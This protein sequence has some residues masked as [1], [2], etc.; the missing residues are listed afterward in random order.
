M[1]LTPR[2]YRTAV[3][4]LS[5]G[6]FATFKP[7]PAGSIGRLLDSRLFSPFKPQADELND[8]PPTSERQTADEQTTTNNKEIRDKEI[9]SEA[10]TIA[11]P[12]FETVKLQAAKIGLP[13]IEA[14]KFFNYY[15]ANG[16]KVGRNPM[17]SLSHTLANWKLRWAERDRPAVKPP[18]AAPTSF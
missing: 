12:D 7:T 15:A 11:R 6:G 14:E 1:G 3:E 5:K 16:W 2:Q 13:D 4:K 9:N 17:R 8:K 10:A 18:K